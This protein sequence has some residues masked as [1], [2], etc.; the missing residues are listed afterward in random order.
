M[1]QRQGAFSLMEL[2]LVVTIIGLLAALAAGGLGNVSRSSSLATAAQRLGDQIALARQSAS[3]LN[4][5]VEVR[6]YQLPEFDTTSGSPI[7]WRGLQIFGQDAS[8][9]ATPLSKPV[10]FPNRVIISTNSV[11]SPLLTS[12]ASTNPVLA[13]G[14]FPATSVRY[15]S[16]TIRP[17]GMVTASTTITDANSF[18]T[19]HQQNEPRPDGIKPA[20]FITIQINPITSKVTLLRP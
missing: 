10:L 5:P 2:L 6:L 17:N 11:I 8:G 9:N 13:V 14:P 3:S 7:L 12:L 20:N 1:R 16:F 4:L 18:V 19:L 15:V